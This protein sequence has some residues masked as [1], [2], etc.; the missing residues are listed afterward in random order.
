MISAYTAYSSANSPS[1]QTRAPE[2]K[3]QPIGFSGRCAA[4]KA[5]T[6][7]NARSSS[8]RTT[9]SRKEEEGSLSEVRNSISAIASTVNAHM[10]HAARVLI[11][12]PLRACSLVPAVTIPLY[13]ATVPQTSRQAL[14]ARNF[15]TS[16]K[17]VGRSLYR[18]S[19]CK[20]PGLVRDIYP[21]PLSGRGCALSEVR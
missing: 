8:E 13:S 18:E 5:P 20:D 19:V 12:P 7:E 11:L 21:P 17:K 2:Q 9:M 6:V 3:S 10:P 14:R 4:T 15:G 1:I 16:D